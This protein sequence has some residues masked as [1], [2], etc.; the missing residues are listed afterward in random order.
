MD[1]GC[2]NSLGI[3]ITNSYFRSK[4]LQKI[5]QRHPRS[6]IW[7]QLEESGPQQPPSD[8]ELP[9]C[10]LGHGPLACCLQGQAE[11]QKDLPC[12][13]L[14]HFQ[15]CQDTE[16]ADSLQEKH[17]AQPIFN[18]QPWLPRCQ[19]VLLSHGYIRE[20]RAKGMLTG[21]RHTGQ[22]AASHRG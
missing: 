18:K 1:R 15:S 4:R 6:H 8:N 22:N 13:Q 17:A 11:G 16:H 20:E 10:R 2:S 3:C 9:Q 12:Q 19:M 5:S 7:H 21:S 14:K